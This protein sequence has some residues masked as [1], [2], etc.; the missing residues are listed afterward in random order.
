[1]YLPEYRRRSW[2]GSL[3]TPTALTDTTAVAP[4]ALQK[5]PP[6][7][8]SFGTGRLRPS[9]TWPLLQMLPHLLTA[10]LKSAAKNAGSASSS[11]PPAIPARLRS[12]ALQTCVGRRYPV[13]YP[14][15]GALDA[16]A[17]DGHADGRNVESAPWRATSD[18]A[19]T[20]VK[21]IFGDRNWQKSSERG[22]L[23][24]SANSINW[25]RLLPQIVYYFFRLPRLCE[26]RANKMR[27]AQVFCVPTGTS[28]T[29]S[30]DGWQGD[31]PAGLALCQLLN[32]NNVLTDFIETGVYD[33]RRLFHV[34]SS[35]SMDILVSSNLERLLYLPVEGHG[36]FPAG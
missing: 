28:A 34:T 19:Q 18:D 35:P 11:P 13:F 29:S 2:T 8:L 15:D 12:R 30:P 16:E 9:R 33:R 36:A 23:L 24:S 20:G 27:R 32:A 5:R 22:W 3:R 21:S 14:R 31:G 25:G 26:L 17:A 10:S 1:M 6:H 7:T 4:C